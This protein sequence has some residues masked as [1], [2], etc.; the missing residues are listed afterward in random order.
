MSVARCMSRDA[1]RESTGDRGKPDA[2]REGG[3]EE[4]RGEAQEG[5]FAGSCQSAR[6]SGHVAP[7]PPP[8]PRVPHPHH[9]DLPHPGI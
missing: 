7:G 3:V 5:H 6:A 9:I 1:A 8:P 2:G 4:Q